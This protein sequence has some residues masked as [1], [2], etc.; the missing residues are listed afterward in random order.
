MRVKIFACFGQC[1]MPIALHMASG[2]E[3]L[4]KGRN[5]CLQLSGSGIMMSFVLRRESCVS[6][7]LKGRRGGIQTQVGLGPV[8]DVF[9][10]SMLSSHNKPERL[11]GKGRTGNQKSRSTQNH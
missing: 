2:P 6:G 8:A 7:I 1:Y 3:V 4:V 10:D 11:L 9:Q 5:E